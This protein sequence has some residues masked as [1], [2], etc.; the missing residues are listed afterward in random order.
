MHGVDSNVHAFVVIICRQ[1]EYKLLQMYPTVV[2]VHITSLC[3]LCM[4]ATAART[5]IASCVTLSSCNCSIAAFAMLCLS[6]YA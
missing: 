3:C 1:A 4:Q 2:E 5:L 6:V